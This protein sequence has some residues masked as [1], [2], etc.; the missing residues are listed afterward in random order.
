MESKLA[1][2]TADQQVKEDVQAQVSRILPR[3]NYYYQ[4]L[5]VRDYIAPQVPYLN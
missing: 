5:S 3:S 4:Y 1:F 2:I